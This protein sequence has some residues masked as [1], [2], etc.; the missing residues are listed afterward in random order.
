ME[1]DT[2]IQVFGHGLNR[3]YELAFMDFMVWTES[4]PLWTE[5]GIHHRLESCEGLPGLRILSNFKNISKIALVA[6]STHLE[7]WGCHLLLGDPTSGCVDDIG[8]GGTTLQGPRTRSR[9]VVF[10]LMGK[11]LWLN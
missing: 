10:E 9:L 2:H 1:L 3:L 11:G 6:I 4:K 8:C 7:S 5:F